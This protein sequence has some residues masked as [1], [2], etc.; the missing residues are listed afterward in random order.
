MRTKD[1]AAKN[2][3]NS[4]VVAVEITH[5]EVDCQS[6]KTWGRAVGSRGGLA[7]GRFREEYRK[8]D[9]RNTLR[10]FLNKIFEVKARNESGIHGRLVGPRANSGI[11]KRI[12]RE[13]LRKPT[14]YDARHWSKN[15][16]T[17]RHSWSHGRVD[18]GS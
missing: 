2:Y 3:L 16:Q 12:V 10:V 13:V 17:R 4:L 1:I 5:N 11:E 15:E 8:F 9:P 6:W 14:A 18:H 7:D